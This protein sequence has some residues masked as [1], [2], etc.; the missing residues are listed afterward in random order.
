MPNSGYL[1][2]ELNLTHRTVDK[3]PVPIWYDIVSVLS[4]ALSGII[5]T[6]SNIVII[7][8]AFL[9]FFDPTSLSKKNHILLFL[10]GF[11][12]I[13]LVSVG[14]YLG[15]AF[16]LNTW[17]LLHPLGFIKKLFNHFKDIAVLKDAVL[18]ILFHTIFFMII[19]VSLGI[20]FY[21]S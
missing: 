17:D 11:I 2:T 20:P 16:R 9:I 19:Y 8:A 18:F 10:S 14:I 1:I 13:F 4:F 7:Q 5:N 3:T 6:L 15:R 21:F 12:L